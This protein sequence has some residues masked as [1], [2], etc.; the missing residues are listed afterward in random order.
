M[1]FKDLLKHNLRSIIIAL[2]FLSIVAS[3][4][5]PISDNDLWWHLATGRW[6]WQNMTIPS[7]DP[8]G[9]PLNL[10]ET[11]L[12]KNFILRQY[13]LS[14]I[15][16]YLLY[17]MGGFKTL[18]MLRALV[19]CL[20]FYLIYR[21]SIKRGAQPLLTAILTF[22]SYM[23]VVREFQ[24]IG[25]KPQIWTTLFSVTTIYLLEEMRG[26]RRPAL[27]ILPAM[28]LLWSNM[29]G[30]FIL[31]DIIILIYTSSS[32]IEKKVTRAF[33]LSV[34]LAILASGIN[35]N[36]YVAFLSTI[37][38]FIKIDRL[39]YLSSIVET[40][41]LFAHAS[42]LGI[43]R[44]LPFFS[45]LMTLSLLSYLINLRNL[46][47]IGLGFILLHALFL[48]M[49]TK[50]IRYIIF[51]ALFCTLIIALNVSLS[52]LMNRFIRRRRLITGL[53]MIS[54]IL[55]IGLGLS[56]LNDGLRFSGLRTPTPYNTDYVR[57]VRFIRENP[58]LRGNVFNDYNHGGFLIWSLYPRI[59]VFMDGRALNLKGF[60]LYRALI[61]TPEARIHRHGDEPI[62]TQFFSYYDINMAILPGCDEASGSVLPIVLTLIKDRQWALIYADNNVLIF[63]RDTPETHPLVER[64]RLPERHAYVNIIATAYAS[65][66]RLY[67]HTLPNWMFSLAVAYEGMGNREVALYWLNRYLKARPSDQRA[68]EMHKRI[69]DSK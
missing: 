45:G 11:P 40:Q 22:L 39:R 57:A 25:V 54:G 43:V 33:L 18:I 56:L 51:L 61:Y 5:T 37:L 19:L 27:F 13:W 58:T 12:R 23:V 38:G 10:D 52:P 60:N 63:L 9:I 32:I 2:F 41:S 59:K 17:R 42:F 35:P 50:A 30:G 53:N 1:T 26:G 55:C 68:L 14:Q 4:T 15:I 16:F 65:R 21:L 67:R 3:L 36:G 64:Y 20:S 66:K 47:S 62:Y 44:S 28:M 31:G 49:A 69:R 46:R 34:I 29:H 48:I 7:D 6:I 8:F 24:Y